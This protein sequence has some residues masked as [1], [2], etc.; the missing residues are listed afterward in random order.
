MKAE[1]NKYGEACESST[2]LLDITEHSVCRLTVSQH[3]RLMAHVAAAVI[4]ILIQSR[5]IISIDTCGCCVRDTLRLTTA[6]AYSAYS[7]RSAYIQLPS[8][9]TRRVDT[10][11]IG[12]GAASQVDSVVR[13]GAFNIT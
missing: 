13:A 2:D 9:V 5:L 11:R 3:V 1:E 10:R 4:V 8:A 7:D 12:V 6:V